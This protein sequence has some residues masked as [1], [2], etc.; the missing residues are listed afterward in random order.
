MSR[1]SI[2]C[3]ASCAIQAG[4]FTLVEL[5]VAL[6]LG[7]IVIAGV[8]SVFLAGQQSFRSNDAL[9]EVQDSSRVAFELMAR[10]IRDAGLTGCNSTNG[11]ITNVLNGQ[12]TNWWANWGNAVHGYD[13]ASTDPALSSVTGDGAPVTGFNS[14]EL[15]NAGSDIAATATLY[16]GSATQFT[17][18]LPA[19]TWKAGDVVVVCTP[20]HAAVLQLNGY[21][22]SSGVATFIQGGSSPG[23]AMTDLSYPPGSNSCT[24]DPVAQ[25][26]RSPAVYCF[27]ANSMMSRLTAVDWYIGTNDAGTQSLYRVSL[28]NK[29]GTPTPTTQEMVRNVDSMAVTYLNPSLSGASGTTFQ[30]ASVI[31]SNNAWAGVTAVNVTLTIGSTFQRASVQGNAAISRPYSFTITLRNR[32]N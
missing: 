16:D 6:V 31:T 19:P 28:V 32:V 21:A 24:T 25:Q 1:R 13:D 14:L 20:G 22:A 27:P 4:G 2:H 26:T 7:L 30:K 8:T 3:N 12:T 17:L 15:I 18:R 10:D 23:N 9:A 11:N 5:M 29:A